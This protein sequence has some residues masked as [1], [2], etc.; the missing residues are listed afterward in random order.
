MSRMRTGA[1]RSCWSRATSEANAAKR[2][3]R[4]RFENEPSVLWSASRRMAS[5]DAG[6]AAAVSLRWTY[7]RHN[8]V[9]IFKLP[10]LCPAAPTHDHAEALALADPVGDGRVRALGAPVTAAAA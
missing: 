8:D 6:G 1:V 10:V 5:P 3:E 2:R 4:R 9:A 7:V